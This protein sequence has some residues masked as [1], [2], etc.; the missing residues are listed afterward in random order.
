MKIIELYFH[1]REPIECGSTIRFHHLTTRK[2]LHSHLFS[3]PLSGSQEVSAFGENGNSWCKSSQ[4]TLSASNSN[5]GVGDTG[6]FWKVVCDGDFW[7]RDDSV[8]FRHVDT[9]VYL[10]SSG[11]CFIYW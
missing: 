11:M 3:S 4:V 6:D 8:V 10:A 5:T 7:E 2:F 9:N 1:F